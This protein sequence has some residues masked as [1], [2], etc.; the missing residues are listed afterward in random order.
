M[1]RFV[2]AIDSE[3]LVINAYTILEAVAEVK[4]LMK[5]V[6]EERNLK[7]VGVKY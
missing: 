4:E 2:F 3:E 7:F 5:V 1:K 6:G